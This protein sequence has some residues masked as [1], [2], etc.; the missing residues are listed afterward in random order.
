MAGLAVGIGHKI[1][2]A[3][4][5]RGAGKV[6]ASGT[7][8]LTARRTIPKVLCGRVT[9]TAACHE[10]VTCGGGAIRTVRVTVDAIQTAEV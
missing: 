3:D 4:V 1:I 2:A 6:S 5:M 9:G 10:S 8:N 7:D